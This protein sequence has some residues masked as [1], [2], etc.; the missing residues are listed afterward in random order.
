[1]KDP[2]RIL[3]MVLGILWAVLFFGLVDLFTVL[4]TNSAFLR[5]I[6]LEASWGAFFTFLV[7]LP[8]CWMA[9]TRAT[10]ESA[11]AVVVLCAS[12][13]A[14]AIGCAVAADPWPLLAV[15]GIVLT[16]GCYFLSPDHRLRWPEL[17]LD[18]LLLALATVGAPGWILYSVRSSE[19]FLVA[20]SYQ[21]MGLEHTPVQIA[22]GIMLTVTPFMLA[23]WPA[24]RRML[25]IAISASAV[26]IGMASLGFPDAIGGFRSVQWSMAAVIWGLTIALASAQRAQSRPLQP[27]L[28]SPHQAPNL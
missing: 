1:M 8:A 15:A 7:A 17:R 28:S 21:S 22:L 11:P 23:F 19:A 24:S 3:A 6:P 25:R 12:G 20:Y 27:G 16:A 4:G 10:Q 14:L 2:G 13:V 18:L 9:V 5:T 26:V